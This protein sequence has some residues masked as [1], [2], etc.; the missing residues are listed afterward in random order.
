MVRVN[1]IGIHSEREHPNLPLGE[2]NYAI[3]LMDRQH[4]HCLRYIRFQNQQ[5]K[6]VGSLPVPPKNKKQNARTGRLCRPNHTVKK[7]IAST[8]RCRMNLETTELHHKPWEFQA[9]FKTVGARGRVSL[10]PPA[11]WLCAFEDT[12]YHDISMAN[13]DGTQVGRNINILLVVMAT[14]SYMLTEQR[15]RWTHAA[16]TKL[17]ARVSH[18]VPTPL[19]DCTVAG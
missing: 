3:W 14:D 18:L 10:F 15:W 19:F 9:A 1:V 4:R 7:P 16:T 8:G 2:D 11:C 12:L 17:S 5:D 13:E 6:I